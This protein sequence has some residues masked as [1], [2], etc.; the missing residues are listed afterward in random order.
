MRKMIRLS[1]A[2][3]IG[4][5]ATSVSR[6]DETNPENPI[7]SQDNAA[8]KPSALDHVAKEVGAAAAGNE[9]EAIETAED[10]KATAPIEATKE[11]AVEKQWKPRQIVTLFRTPG[12]EPKHTKK[13]ARVPYYTLS[14][15]DVN[16][17]GN[18]ERVEVRQLAYRDQEVT[19]ASSGTATLFC[20]EF[21]LKLSGE[22]SETKY[23]FECPGRLKLQIDGMQID[24]DS[25]KLSDGELQLENATVAIRGTV[26]ASAHMAIHLDIKGVRT[27]E[28]GMVPPEGLD[29]QP[30]PHGVIAPLTPYPQ[31]SYQPIPDDNFREGK[32]PAGDDFDGPFGL[33]EEPSDRSF[34]R[35]RSSKQNQ[36]EFFPRP[37][38]S[39]ANTLN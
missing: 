24:C 15:Q 5:N 38:F 31:K 17:G 13:T 1:L 19:V 37:Q 4:F 7:A 25:G 16:R 29:L 12:G 21:S 36:P 22:S 2:V 32:E 10:A 27:A 39:P 8:T 3:V 23:D 26:V 20:D 30:P 28:F 18:T 34:R 35:T 33:E 9:M 6:A 14:Y 11:V